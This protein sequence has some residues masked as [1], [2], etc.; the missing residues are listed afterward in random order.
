MFF[1]SE[2]IGC[3]CLEQCTC[4]DD[5]GTEIGPGLLCVGKGGSGGVVASDA[6]DWRLGSIG[7]GLDLSPEAARG[8][9]DKLA[10][11]TGL[12]RTLRWCINTHFFISAQI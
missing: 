11:A 9:S 10:G 7:E 2:I 6:G 12:C 3:R 1:A 8:I 5:A 4:L